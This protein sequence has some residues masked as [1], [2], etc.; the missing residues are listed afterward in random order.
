M[1][2]QDRRPG[3]LGDNLREGVR[4][5]AGILGALKDAVEESFDEL[6]ARGDLSPER[7]REAARATM[8][9]AQE[10]L[11]TMRERFDFVSRREF[12][13]LR[14]EVDALRARF[15]AHS[16][17]HTHGSGGTG[18]AAAKGDTAGGSTAGGFP[19]DGG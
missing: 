19:V 8:Q 5:V 11:E 12:D 4:T 18:G 9:R 7:A 15:D 13:A 3:D 2:S 17:P 16:H 14:A 1:S 6:R 10:E